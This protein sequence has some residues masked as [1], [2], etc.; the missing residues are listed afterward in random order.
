MEARKLQ[1]V[2]SD[3]PDGLVKSVD[4]AREVAGKLPRIILTSLGLGDYLDGQ[5]LMEVIHA[6][7]NNPTRKQFFHRFKQVSHEQGHAEYDWHLPDLGGRFAIDYSHP[8]DPI[9]LYQPNGS[10]SPW[11]MFRCIL[12][13]YRKSKIYA[14]DLITGEIF[15]SYQDAVDVSGLRATLINANPDLKLRHQT[16]SL[17]ELVDELVVQLHQYPERFPTEQRCPHLK[18]E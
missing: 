15:Y 12:G 16:I 9:P 3:N 10:R 5:K 8:E 13:P 6:P 17:V 1:Y 14:G 7:E 18:V 2:N 11:E 4:E